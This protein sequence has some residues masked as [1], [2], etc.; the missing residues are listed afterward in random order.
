MKYVCTIY[1]NYVCQTSDN[2]FTDYVKTINVGVI[3]SW[4]LFWVDIYEVLDVYL[5]HKLKSSGKEQESFNITHWV[6]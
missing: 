4:S 6:V 2:V 5:V 3:F 1:M